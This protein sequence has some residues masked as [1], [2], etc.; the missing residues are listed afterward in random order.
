ML[1]NDPQTVKDELV[2]YLKAFHVNWEKVKASDL[3]EMW[4]SPGDIRKYSVRE[5]DLLVC[6]GGEGGRAGI[7]KDPP[8]KCIIQNALHRVRPRK[9]ND[10]QFL[11]YLLEVVSHRGWFDILCNKATIAHF[12]AEK[13]GWLSIILPPS[14]EQRTIAAFLDRETARIDALME[15]KQR[16]TELLK[17]KR[18][19]LISHAVT[20]GLEGLISAGISQSK[21]DWQDVRV[22][23][24]IKLQ[25]GFDI[26]GANESDGQVPVI[27]SGGL[28][29][30][31]D[32]A[33]VKGPG[34]IVGRKGTLGT[35]NYVEEDYWP[36]D[37][38]LWVKEFRG[39]FPR[40]VY[41]FLIHM[42]LEKLDVGAANPTLNRNHVHP[43]KVRWPEKETQETIAI[44]LDREISKINALIAKIQE[45]IDRLKEY[46]TALISAV[47]TGRIDVRRAGT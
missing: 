37:T 32:K 2:P 46:R 4:A 31:S 5:G 11:M 36:H 44:F 34:V 6:E 9:D 20:K 29:G 33:M 13:F 47:V 30:Y 17:E 41:Y 25:R 26:T 16:Q 15:K 7:L 12:T 39:N 22:G 10:N 43:I 23:R 35:V 3:P 19:A 8:L 27:S 38:T 1:Q 18:S 40:Y 28:S 21:P 24:V 45:S 14:Y 42:K